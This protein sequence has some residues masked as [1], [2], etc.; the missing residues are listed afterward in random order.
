VIDRA[1]LPTA[2]GGVE[3]SDGLRSAKAPAPQQCRSVAVI[4]SARRASFKERRADRM[5]E[6][7]P[8]RRG[9]QVAA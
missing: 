1:L 7:V 5:I 8:T 3:S 2:R 6:P 9:E 4:S